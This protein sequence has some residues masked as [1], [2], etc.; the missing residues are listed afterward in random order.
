[1]RVALSTKKIIHAF[2]V[3]ACGSITSVYQE[4]PLSSS[5]YARML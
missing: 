4:D 1:M 2:R 5:I 3:A